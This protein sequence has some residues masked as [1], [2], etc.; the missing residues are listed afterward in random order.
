MSKSE[1]AV[2]GLSEFEH[3]VDRLNLASEQSQR[4]KRTNALISDQYPKIFAF[5]ETAL[6]NVR[7]GFDFKPPLSRFMRLIGAVVVQDRAPNESIFDVVGVVEAGNIG[8]RSNLPFPDVFTVVWANKE[9]FVDEGSQRAVC[10]LALSRL[11]I[12]SSHEEAPPLYS[13]R[14]GL[15]VSR[16]TEVTYCHNNGVEQ[17]LFGQHKEAVGLELA[18]RRGFINEGVRG[19]FSDTELTE[20]LSDF[21]RSES[22]Y[23][24]GGATLQPPDLLAKILQSVID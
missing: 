10:E 16:F 4:I 20:M 17:Y 7:D 8:N 9:V 13:T 19:G 22:A 11:L 18:L 5:L 1:I 21:H 23:R 6:R 14:M 3:I 24:L 12:D 15:A 2:D